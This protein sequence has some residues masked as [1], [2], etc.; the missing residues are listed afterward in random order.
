MA[1][2]GIASR[3]SVGRQEPHRDWSRLYVSSYRIVP[4]AEIRGEEGSHDGI[5]PWQ[6][7]FSCGT[8]A[9]D[10]VFSRKITKSLEITKIIPNQPLA[11]SLCRG[12]FVL[13]S[14]EFPI[15]SQLW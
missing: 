3:K 4:E 12:I 15:F 6:E 14:A 5:G 11:G 1:I 2:H 10:I 9:S 7:Q 13:P 8:S